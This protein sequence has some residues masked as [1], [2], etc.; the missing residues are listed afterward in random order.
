MKITRD[1]IT[2]LLPVYQSGE[3]SQDTRE[4]VDAFL[5]EDPEFA[6]LVHAEQGSLPLEH[7]PK[8][9]K[10]NEMETLERT[11]KLLKQRTWYAA[12]GI[13]F[14]LTAFSFNFESNGVRWN[15]H[16]S[17]AVAAVLFVIGLFFWV[18]YAQTHGKLKGSAL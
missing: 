13:F 17:P 15:W 14:C 2:D 3:A 9:S 4:L 7:Q 6:R 1:V 10:E 8:L 18:K 12:S 11:K 16:D 5:K